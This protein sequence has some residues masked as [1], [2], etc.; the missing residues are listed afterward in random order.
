M[1][2]V[3]AS[4]MGKTEK[5]IEKLAIDAMKIE[6]GTETVKGDYIL[7]TYTDGNGVVPNIVES[8]LE[9]NSDSLKGVVAG[10]SRERHAAT[11]GW[12]GDIISKKYNVPC[13]HKV[14]GEGSEED[15]EK[16][17]QMIR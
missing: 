9:N 7:F 16:I 6:N 15:V 3:Y 2:Y 14:D 1:T 8:F 5:L 11:F 12:A 4:R 13:L 17:K 10:G